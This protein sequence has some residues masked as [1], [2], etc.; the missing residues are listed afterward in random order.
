MELRVNSM[1]LK[2][3]LAELLVN[4]HEFKLESIGGKRVYVPAIYSNNRTGTEDS[5][6]T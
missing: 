5:Y 1:E 6:K 4:L 2:A 3:K